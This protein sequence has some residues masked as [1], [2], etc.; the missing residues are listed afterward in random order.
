MGSRVAGKRKSMQMQGTVD[1]I[2]EHPRDV[3]ADGK[4]P[5][6]PINLLYFLAEDIHKDGMLERVHEAHAAADK[7]Y[8]EMDEV[9]SVE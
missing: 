2:L 6:D 3:N 8:E 4:R 9:N 7:Y 5:G 1:F